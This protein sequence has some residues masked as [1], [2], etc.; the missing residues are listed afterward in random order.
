MQ[1]V[2]SS[3]DVVVVGNAGVD[4]NVYFYTDEIDFSVEANFTQN[5]DYVGQAGGYGA[6]G[7]AQLGKRTAFIGAVGDDPNGGFVRGEL[8][9]DGVDLTG[10]FYDPAGTARSINFMYKDGRRKNF[11]DGKGHM[12]LHP[13]LEVCRAV[14]GRARLAHFNIPNWARELLPL[15][16]ELGLTI[17]CDIQDVVSPDDPYRQDFIRE[18]DILFFSAAN[19]ADPT[20]L[21]HRFLAEG[22]ARVV[23][24]GMGARGCLLGTR[25]GV[26][27]FGPV[28]LPEPVV[29]TNG[30]GDALA[31]GF[32]SSYVL[33]GFSVEQAILR[34]QIAARFTCTKKATSSELI[35]AAQLAYFWERM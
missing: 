26:R 14:L 27:A 20:P 28:S 12:V 9:R 29:D 13:D 4:T 25:E 18:A 10:V 17:S 24:A 1:N 32:L 35:S 23:V 21:I 3:L 34:G 2:S 6:R 15:A 16:R 30:A 33:E 11:Y 22:P 5:V 8:A 31:V 19:F 7:F